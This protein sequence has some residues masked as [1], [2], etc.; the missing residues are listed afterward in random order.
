MAR[1][2]SS[3]KNPRFTWWFWVIVA[4]LITTILLT[5]FMMYRMSQKSKSLQP[6]ASPSSVRADHSF[7]PTHLPPIIQPFANSS[8]DMV[9]VYSS[10]CGWCDRFNPIWD[11]FSRQY[12]GS[13]NLVK[14]E[15]RDP[16]ASKYKITGFPTVLI[17]K[18][19]VQG[20]M[21]N[22]E[23]TVENLVKFAAAHEA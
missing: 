23:R 5:V 21:F 13:L 16:S 20:P 4:L 11:D 12:Q 18:N 3:R 1:V 2:D 6:T 14:V 15:T 22:D 17:M 7:A 8:V 10:S 9:Y 19:G